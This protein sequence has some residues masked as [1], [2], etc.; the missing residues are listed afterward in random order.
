MQKLSEKFWKIFSMQMSLWESL[1]A[2]L[3]R[4]NSMLIAFYSTEFSLCGSF[5]ILAFNFNCL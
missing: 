2:F 1:S 4:E 3:A 5:E